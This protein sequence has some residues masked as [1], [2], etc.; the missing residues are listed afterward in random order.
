MK[1]LEVSLL[2]LGIVNH[3]PY[4][5]AQSQQTLAQDA[6]S[7]ILG[8]GAPILGSDMGC[9]QDSPTCDWMAKVP[10]ET[11]IVHMNLP[12]THDAA[13][14]NYSQATQDSLIRYTGSDIPPAKVFR[15]Q[16]H[17]LFDMLNGGIRVFD[18]RYSWNPGNDTVGFYHGAALLAPT[19]RIEDVFFG[20]YSWLDA[21]PTET[22]LV[23]MNYEGGPRRENTAEL[24]EHIYNLFE[25]PLA[26]RYWMQTNGRLG[27]LGEA[28]GK[29]ILLQRFAYSLLPGDLTNR[30][31]IALPPDLWTDN[32]P[33]IELVYNQDEDRI[34]YIE[35]FYEPHPPTNEP[36]DN[37]AEINILWK[38]N[39]TIAH[40]E[41]AGDSSNETTKDQLFITFASAENNEEHVFPKIMALGNGTLTTG[42]NQRLL[43]WLGE[44]RGQR[45]GIVMLDFFDTVPGLVE[46]VIDL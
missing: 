33:N 26:K 45:R 4:S 17:S 21:H 37:R 29:I 22:I 19:T 39:A 30:V 23:S 10:D 24:Q 6:L 13:T 8:R 5:V 32:G 28:R 41:R 31:G 18:L 40:L 42:V 36:P 16:E 2:I 35:D 12:G 27:T 20:F 3:I 43:E 14:W 25:S 9:G 15:C 34:A 44:K 7:D 46:A 1:A 11:Q 38:F